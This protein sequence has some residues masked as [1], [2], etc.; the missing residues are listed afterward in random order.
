[1]RPE[2]KNIAR[3]GDGDGVGLGRE[4]TLLNGVIRF[5]EN[6]LV[7]LIESKAGDFDRS[8]GQ[9]QLLELNLQLV[10]V[11]L[12]LVDLDSNLRLGRF[13]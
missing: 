8:V 6:D 11:P 9:D 5:A 2:R 7:D 3:A 13:G 12:A 10:K 4:G 1:M